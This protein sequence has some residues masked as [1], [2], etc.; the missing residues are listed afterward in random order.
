M[1]KSHQQPAGDQRGLAGDDRL[2]ERAVSRHPRV[3]PRHRIIGERPHPVGILPRGEIL[4]GA[5]ADMAGGDA[6]HDGAGQAGLADHGLP[7]CYRSQRAGGGDAERVHRLSDQVFAQDRSEGR[8]PVP[9]AGEWGASGTLQLDVAAADLPQQI[10]APVAEPRH[11]IAELVAGVGERHRLRP[12]RHMV[13][14]QHISRQVIRIEPELLGQRDVQLDQ[15]RPRD[16]RGIEPRVEPFGQPGIGV[17]E[18]DHATQMAQV[19]GL[20]K[21]GGIAAGR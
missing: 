19:W 10:G 4:K 6:G 5:D 14:G 13:A 2:Q 11:E 9:T 16:G 17:G 20:G 12:L 3:M 21:G 8:A 7:G 15:P 18:W 1:N